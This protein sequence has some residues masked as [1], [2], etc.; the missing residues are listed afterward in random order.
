MANVSVGVVSV[1]VIKIDWELSSM[2]SGLSDKI[3][4][5]H[6]C[7]S[8]ATD[9]ASDLKVSTLPGD[10]QGLLVGFTGDRCMKFEK[11]IFWRCSPQFTFGKRR[12]RLADF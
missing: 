3:T 4:R 7:L 10:I 6:S 5:L 1:S 12:I 8:G 11:N 2:H 9:F